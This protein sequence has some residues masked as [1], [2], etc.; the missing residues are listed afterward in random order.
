MKLMKKKFFLLASIISI[1]VLAMLWFWN[2]SPKTSTEQ[3]TYQKTTDLSK[4]YLRLRLSTDDVLLNAKQYEYNEW[5]D[6]MTTLIQAW[7]NLEKESLELEKLATEMAEEKVSFYLVPKAVAYDKQE[8]SDVFD[9]APAGKKI[10]T[11]AKFLGIDAKRA[12]KILQND[13]EMLKADAWNEAGDTFQ[14]LETSAVVIKDGC[15]V[16]GFV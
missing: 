8:I 12:F 6:K 10:R 4:E 5:N 15:K 9:K 1:S 3:L 14:K 2:A 11:L 16:A 13:Q 7:G